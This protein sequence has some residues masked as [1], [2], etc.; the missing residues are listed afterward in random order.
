MANRARDRRAVADLERRGYLV[1]TIW[2]CE[3]TNPATVRRR[4]KRLTQRLMNR[5]S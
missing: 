1:I 4:L 3:L 5:P 2:E